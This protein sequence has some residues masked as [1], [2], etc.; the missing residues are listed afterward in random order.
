MEPESRSRRL[1]S[2]TQSKAKMYE[3]GIPEEAHIEIPTDPARLFN[4]TIGILGDIS[5]LIN[6]GTINNEQI[7]EFRESLV[8]S[9]RF[10]DSYLQSFLSTELNPYLLLLG[11]ASYYLC[12]LPGS[13]WILA[14]RLDKTKLDLDCSGLEHLLLW[15]LRLS[16]STHPD[17]LSEQYGDHINEISEGLIEFYKIGK[18][19]ENLLEY[20]SKLRTKVYDIG[21]PRQLLFADVICAIVRKRLEYST[22]HCLPQYSDIPVE[23]WVDTLKKEAFLRELWPAQQLMG[24]KNVFRGKS[25]VVQMPTSAGKTRAIE[26]IIRSAFLSERASLAVIV[27][28]Y[29]ALCHEIRNSLLRSFRGES[30]NVNELTDVLQTDFNITE[31]LTVKQVLAV[32]PEKLLYVLRHNPELA[33][34][35][36]LLI[37]D[38]GHQFDSGIRGIT[39]ELLLTSLKLMVP[40]EIQTV[41]ISAVISNADAIGNW[42][43]GENF[44]VVYGTGLIPT[45]RTIAFTSWLDRLGRLDFI[46]KD[47]PDVSDFFVPRV[48]VQQ[49]LSLKGRERKKQQFP[50]RN[51]GQSVALFLGLKLAING[52]IAIFCGRKTTA[53]NL[54]SKIVD[55]YSRDLQLPKPVEFSNREEVQKLAYLYACNLGEGAAATK[56]AQ[57]G[58][59]THHANIPHGIRLA[60]EYAMKNGSVIFIICTSTLAQGVNLPIRYLIVTGIYQG[61][62]PIKVRDFHNLIGR[63]GRADRHTEGSIIFADPNI[64]D[65]RKSVDGVRRWRQFIKLLEPNNSEPCASSL[66]SIFEPLYSADRRYTIRIGIVEIVSLYIESP[67]ELDDFIERICSEHADKGF[68]REGLDVQ[69]SW[70]LKIISSIENYLMAQWDESKPSLPDDDVVILASETLAYFLADDEQKEQIIEIFLMLEKNIEKNVPEPSR[71]KIFGRTLYGVHTSMNIESWVNQHVEEIIACDEHEELLIAIWSLLAE[72]I[73]NNTFRKCDQPELLRD[74]ALEWVRGKTYHELL[75]MMVDSDARIKAGQQRRHLNIEH[76]VDICEN[77]FA[78]DGTLILGAITEVIQ[79]I[80]PEDNE[81]ITTMLTGLQK[82]LKYGLPTSLSISICELGFADRVIALDLSSFLGDISVDRRTITRA[83]RRDEQN[84]RDLLDKYPAYFMERLN[85]L[86]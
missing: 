14:K 64:F 84:V 43:N 29:R 30:I 8:F 34:N 82:K 21:T 76:V 19:E 71:R 17:G 15:L 35:I 31:L 12:G 23:Q 61:P 28:P 63:T 24:G 70:K 44:E 2:I 69:M 32:T 59:F 5:A 42:L 75:Q 57:I 80:K 16:L 10:F 73:S 47:N 72:N 38:E 9:A 55:A 86:L 48:I 22:W 53:V 79:L 68:T 26:I 77:G 25:A 81:K 62:E 58:I 74:I 6:S 33:E 50:E 65:R 36:G 7:D 78:Y 39:Y 4:L 40:S 83:I 27:A 1:L 85:N 41:L 20:T 3:Y 54:C 51:D 45:Y 52:S 18:G 67:Q 46:S 66:L 37:Y 13:S 11:S 60:T 49:Q 56:S